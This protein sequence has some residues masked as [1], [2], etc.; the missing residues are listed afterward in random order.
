VVVCGAYLMF[1][2]AAAGWFQAEAIFHLI[3]ADRP[4]VHGHSSSAS[5][6]Y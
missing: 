2:S 1:L 4:P 5:H 6:E 3:P